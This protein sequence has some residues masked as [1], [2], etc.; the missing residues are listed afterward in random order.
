MPAC[1]TVPAP[2]NGSGQARL[3]EPLYRGSSSVVEAGAHRAARQAVGP[4]VFPAPAFHGRSTHKQCGP[5]GCRQALHQYQTEGDAHE[6][7][8]AGIA[9]Q[10]PPTFSGTLR[11]RRPV[12]PA[13]SG[14]TP[15][16]A[17][18]T[19]CSVIL[20]N[21]LT[22]GKLSARSGFPS[23]AATL[24][25]WSGCSRTGGSTAPC[26]SPCSR[27]ATGLIPASWTVGTSMETKRKKRL[28]YWEKVPCWII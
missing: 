14:S 2:G 4:A 17:T 15:T 13:N 7:T 24:T 25:Y 18:W 23:R 1:S 3:E 8:R 20:R 28:P 21:P 22:N 5:T 27:P 12:S 11:P 9:R 16:T 6:A 19:Q 26:A 10:P